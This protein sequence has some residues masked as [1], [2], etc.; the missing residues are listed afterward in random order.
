MSDHREDF[1]NEIEKKLLGLT[2]KELQQCCE[3][4]NL[5]GK[6][7][8]DIQNK[9]RRALVKYVIQFCESTELLEMEDEGMSVLLELNDL[10]DIL[11][12]S[13]PETVVDGAAPHTADKR[14]EQVDQPMQ[15][16]RGAQQGGHTQPFSSQEQH[17]G[18]VAPENEIKIGTPYPMRYI[19]EKKKDYYLF[20]K[21]VC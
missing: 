9:G 17:A 5:T 3:R 7:Y 4:S 15:P 6:G 2:V 10:L 21:R 14:E 11:Q 13:Q 8:V 19:P 1:L 18:M 20:Q 12:E 16:T